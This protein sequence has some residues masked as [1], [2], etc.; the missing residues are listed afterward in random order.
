MNRKEFDAKA[1]QIDSTAYELAEQIEE[2]AKQ[3]QGHDWPDEVSGCV[4]ELPRLAKEIRET[5]SCVG[6]TF[7]TNDEM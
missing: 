2:L 6:I 7:K 5:G 3:A 1:E 4:A